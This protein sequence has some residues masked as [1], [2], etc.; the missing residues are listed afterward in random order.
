MWRLC[1]ACTGLL[2]PLL[3]EACEHERST[4]EKQLRE[5]VSYRAEAIVNA[6]GDP[7]SI[8]PDEIELKFVDSRSR[9][10]GQIAGAIAYD[11][12][13]RTVIFPRR[14][15]GTTVPNP[16]RWARSYWP[17][18]QDAEYQVAFPI[19]EAIDNTLWGAYLQEA[20]R[21]DGGT[22]P[23]A[24]CSSVDVR[25]RLPCEMLVDGVSEHIKTLRTP[26]FNANRLDRIWPEEF[27]RFSRRVWRTDPEYMDVQR[28]G[29]ILLVQPLIN[30]FGM[31]RALAYVAR[32][33]FRVEDDNLRTSALRYQEQAREALQIRLTTS[34]SE[35][36]PAVAAPSPSSGTV[37]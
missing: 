19:I 33:P 9:E 35:L 1:I 21:R 11:P 27:G 10:F 30:E 16:L 32:T 14:Y 5:L 2:L 26:L 29:G 12:E 22:W 7:L 36:R 3:C 6:F 23:H 8:F 15:V 34:N 13:R 4:C 24:G 25:E 28:Y 17:Y 20:A 18:Y 31:P 37:H